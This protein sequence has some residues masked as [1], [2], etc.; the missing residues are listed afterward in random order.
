MRRHHNTLHQTKKLFW[1]TVE[2]CTRSE[3]FPSG[4][5]FPRKDKLDSHIRNIHHAAV[6]SPGPS[7]AGLT[8][9]IPD[10]ADHVIANAND[11][12]SNSGEPSWFYDNA[13]F[14]TLPAIDTTVATGLLPGADG[15]VDATGFPTVDGQ[16]G[17]A[18]LT[19]IT[20]SITTADGLTGTNW[21][22][23]VDDGLTG[24]NGF[25]ASGF[26]D[27]DEYTRAD[28]FNLTHGPIGFDQSAPADGIT[29]AGWPAFAH[30]NNDEFPGVDGIVG[31][32]W[33]AD[34]TWFAGVNGFTDVS[35][36]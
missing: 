8:T 16:V 15:L 19:E 22:S 11:I 29:G 34:S 1:C 26:T 3:G 24:T 28:G 20:A 14:T 13:G 30:A 10:F 18:G 32:N 9:T 21:F 5:P 4:K 7:C 2:G 12:A 33:F 31:D 27:A 6:F 23:F 35:G 36:V 25:S 17:V